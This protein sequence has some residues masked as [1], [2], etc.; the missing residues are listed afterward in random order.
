MLLSF[1]FPGLHMKRILFCALFLLMFLAASVE[2]SPL[3]DTEKLSDIEQLVNIV[4]ASYGPKQYK[5]V[6]FGIDVDEIK[7]RYQQLALHTTSNAEFYYLIVKLVAEFKDS[8]FSA[9]LPSD[10]RA[11]LGFLT[12]YVDGKVLITRVDRTVLPEYVFP[13][14]RGDEIIAVNGRPVEEVV[15]ELANHLGMGNELTAQRL[16]TM[17][18]PVRSGTVVPVP[19]GDVELSI[20]AHNQPW[21]IHAVTL[22]WQNFGTPL[23]E[24]INAEEMKLAV[25]EDR[26]PPR[27][28][29]EFE[30]SMHSTLE[31]IF[32]DIDADFLCSGSTR[33]RI[34]A[35]ASIIMDDPFVAY[36]HPTSIGNI[37][38]LRI[39]HYIPVNAVTGE[40]EFDLGFAQYEYAISVLEENTVGLIID[41]D[42]NCGGSVD[43]L[44]RMV[45]LFIDDAYEPI[46]FQLLAS[47]AEYLEF[48]SWLMG[49][50]SQTL[51][52][53][54]LSEVVALIKTH[55]QVGDFLTAKT[56]ISGV[57]EILPNEVRYTK[58]I[59]MLIDE[60]SGSGGDAFPS[61]MQGHGRV[62][63]LGSKTMGAGGHVVE[64][65]SLPHSG[66][67]IRM[68]K[69]LFFRP[70]GV[71]VEN[72]GV[73]PDISYRHTVEDITNG[74]TQ[75]QRFYLEKLVEL[76]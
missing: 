72:N 14:R 29:E 36:Y 71:P 32:P 55:W 8:H 69:S 40:T 73:V 1:T 15:E 45:G 53:H 52:Y 27:T 10:Y 21:S 60:M 30:L 35:D 62:T 19:T 75:Y 58:P 28:L 22:T 47:K 64:Q 74:F 70:D 68:T 23:D 2:S 13:F 12:D 61:L 26:S 43:Y 16:A 44:E 54:G 56:S 76:L 51:E 31:D 39:G 25:V 3:T 5:L 4:K 6:N 49:L 18:I 34:P 57:K 65:P 7:A 11:T 50:N 38:Y 48:K 63:L 42:H 46:Q 17:I 59:I 67:R 24:Q 41:Q 20:I 66:I 33:I 37:G 9:R